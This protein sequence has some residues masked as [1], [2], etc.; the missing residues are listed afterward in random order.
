[1]MNEVAVVV[2]APVAAPMGDEQVVDLEGLHNQ[3]K[4]LES[5]DLFKVLKVALAEAERKSKAIAKQ[6][7]KPVKVQ[8]EK[9]DKK[10]KKV[11]SQPKGP[12][13]P[14]LRINCAWVNFI[15]ERAQAN[16]WESYVV[17]KKDEEIEMS[18]S[19]ELNGKHVFADSV[20][21][22]KPTGQGL[23]HGN[24]MSLASWTKKTKKGVY[25]EFLSK[26]ESEPVE[27]KAVV[28]KEPV[29]RKT[30]AE[31]QKEKEEKAELALKEK[32]EKAEKREEEKKAKME[33]KERLA[34]EKKAEKA[35]KAEKPKAEKAAKAEKPKAEKVAKVE[36]PATPV[37]EGVAK[38]APGAP[39]KAKQVVEEEWKCDNDK[40]LHRWSFK[41]QEYLRN[42]DNEVYR[43][44]EDGEMGEWCGMY[45]P[46]ENR[47]DDS[48]EEPME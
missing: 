37:K 42:Y 25:D 9:K 30:A 2:V 8:K 48:V 43:P 3:L 11:G 45:I 10:E 14:Q 28:V 35:A 46:G 6:A 24:A 5:G 1:M 36:K 18:C 20:T 44:T 16:G 26:Y 4:Q 29:V 7:S 12:T 17:S 33:E 27:E 40:L 22:K 13:P 47:I 15:K 38:K 32:Q 34:A 31:K 21:E 19:T 41:G 23:T 39:V